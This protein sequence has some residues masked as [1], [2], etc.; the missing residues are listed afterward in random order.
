MLGGA[1]GVTEPSHSYGS[2]KIHI[3]TD[4]FHVTP[5]T[6]ESDQYKERATG[7][8]SGSGFC[9]GRKQ[10]VTGRG[11]SFEIRKCQRLEFWSSELIKSRQLRDT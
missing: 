11:Q 1:A 6:A 4:V 10:E 8:S 3:R 7:K 2:P 9:F 5:S